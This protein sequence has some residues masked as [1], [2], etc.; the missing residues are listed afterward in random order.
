MRVLTCDV[1]TSLHHP[2]SRSGKLMCVGLLRDGNYT[3][4]DIEHSDLPYG[5]EL[6]LVKREIEAAEVI[7]GHN[8]KYDISWLRMYIPDLKINSVWDTQLFEYIYSDQTWVMPSLHDCLIKHGMCGKSDYIKTEYW[9]KGIDTAEV[10]SN[11]LKDYNRGDCTSTYELYRTQ[12]ALLRLEQRSLFQLHCDD[13]LVL[14]EMEF[15][16][17]MF[18]VDECIKQQEIYKLKYQELC[19]K[20]KGLY[21]DVPIN[22]NSNDHLSAVLYG[23]PVS[24]RVREVVQKTFKKGIKDV[25]RWGTKTMQLPRLVDPIKGSQ[26]DKEGL[27]FVS[28]PVLRSLKPTTKRAREIIE[29]VLELAEVEKLLNTYYLGLPKLI[30]EQNW[31]AGMIHGSFNQ[32]VTRTGRSSSSKPNEQNFAARIKHLFTSRFPA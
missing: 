10:P 2:F 15:N 23:G 7:V 1:E 29:L 19:D 32:C 24:F 22:W 16:G 11:I 30:D 27:F 31:S 20:L 26:R 14:Q 9:D 8:I 13:L 4:V 6:E 21:P 17:M 25:E 18:D 5:E 3:Y 12:K 28:E